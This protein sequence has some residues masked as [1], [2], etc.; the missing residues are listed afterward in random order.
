MRLRKAF[1]NLYAENVDKQIVVVG[2]FCVIS[3]FFILLFLHRI[4]AFLSQLPLKQI[5]FTLHHIILTMAFIAIP[6]LF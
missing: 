4:F 3:P 5:V 6:Y 1:T 2:I